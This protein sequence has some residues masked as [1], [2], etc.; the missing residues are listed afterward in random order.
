MNLPMI[1]DV[2]G[3]RPY[4]MNESMSQYLDELVERKAK[5]AAAAAEKEAQALAGEA[6]AAQTELSKDLEDKQGEPSDN[7]EQEDKE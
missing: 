4:G 6:D 5:E 2:L 3:D 1:I 7:K